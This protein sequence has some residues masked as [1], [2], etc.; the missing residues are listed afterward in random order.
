[1]RIPRWL[2]TLM[3]T[4]SVLIILATAGWWWVTWPERTARELL[5]S[6]ATGRLEAAKQMISQDPNDPFEWPPPDYSWVDWG[7]AKL[8]P[9]SRTLG[10]LVGGRQRIGLRIGYWVTVERGRVLHPGLIFTGR[11]DGTGQI[12]RPLPPTSGSEPEQE[13]SDSIP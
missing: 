10:D 7:Q 13:T 11:L 3:L 8:E 4:S 1:M 9:Q 2:V 6:L 5:D 12:D